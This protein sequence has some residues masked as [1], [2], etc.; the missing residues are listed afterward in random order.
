MPLLFVVQRELDEGKL[1]GDM[2]IGIIKN[3]KWE[4][5]EK[6]IKEIEE[7]EAKEE[8]EMKKE[9][10]ERFEEVCS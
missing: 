2:V 4:A 1:V 8:E 9:M 6:K 3:P 7:K 10:K 5:I